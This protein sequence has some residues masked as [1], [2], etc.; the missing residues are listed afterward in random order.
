[1]IDLGDERGVGGL[2]GMNAQGVEPRRGVGLCLAH[3]FQDQHLQ[4][5]E[6]GVAAK[7]WPASVRGVARQ[8]VRHGWVSG[9]RAQPSGESGGASR[10]EARP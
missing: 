5:G 1:M 6:V 3:Q 4:S 10:V 2:D 9:L 8:E 7:R